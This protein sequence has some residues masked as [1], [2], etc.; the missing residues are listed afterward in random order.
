MLFF[1]KVKSQNVF[2]TAFIECK[3][4]IFLNAA[5]EILV[6]YL[7]TTMSAV[8]N[9]NITGSQVQPNFIYFLDVPKISHF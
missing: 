4:V 9:C 1:Y 6:N 2:F 3:D 7:I 5:S 8:A